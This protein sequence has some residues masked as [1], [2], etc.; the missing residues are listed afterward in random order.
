[1][2]AMKKYGLDEATQKEALEELI[3]EIGFR[4][5]DTR[6]RRQRTM[7][8]L[9]KSRLL[10]EK[11]RNKSEEQRRRE[12]ELKKQ[13]EQRQAEERKRKEEEE[14]K[15]KKLEEEER[16]RR[17]MK[18][19][20]DEYTLEIYALKGEY[21]T[22][23]YIMAHVER[24]IEKMPFEEYCI[25]QVPWNKLS[26]KNEIEVV[27][28]IVKNGHEIREQVLINVMKHVVNFSLRKVAKLDLRAVVSI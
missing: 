4:D 28:S 16:E 7:D 15:K 1:M 9:R 10:E 2:D 23:Q 11:E 27:F 24:V 8:Q 21:P 3:W 18:K 6:M 19:K 14:E 5:Y 12:E 20:V 22:D 17:R 26:T 13:E 25:L